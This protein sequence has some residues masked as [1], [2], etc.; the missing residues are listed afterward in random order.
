LK[1]RLLIPGPTEIDPEI[2]AAAARP[3]IGHRGPEMVELLQT[4]LPRVQRLLNTTNSVYP[5]ACSATG[6]MEATIRNAAP[7]RFLHL[8]CGAFGQRWSEIRA[9]CGQPGDDLAVEWGQASAPAALREQLQKDAYVAVT[10]V[11]NETSTGVLNPLA[12]LAQVVRSQSDA[13]LCVDT[14]SSMGA[15]EL[16][17]DRWGVDVC[18]AGTQKALALAPGLTLCAVSQR[19]LARSE[20]APSKG[21][22]FDFLTHERSLAKWQ[23]PATPAIAQ[24]FQL[25]LQMQRIEREGLAAR[26][27]RHAAM[28]D[29]TLAF[30]EAH[31]MVPF[32]AAGA[33]S[34]TVTTLRSG[35]RDLAALLSRAR[36]RGIILGSGYGKT[37]GDVFRVGH[38]GE[39]T[40]AELNEVLS[41]LDEELGR[42]AVG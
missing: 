34:V 22:Y 31:G 14:V 29:R 28:R 11:H 20:A 30:G 7:G 1:K 9:A 37:K 16:Q 26:Y 4:T 21:V 6:A 15:V 10:L 38:M 33:R 23:T 32:A 5:L 19:A 35:G 40:V 8:V 25:Q 13:L 41:M 27:A 12:E 18:L 36:E 39:W 2:A 24:L 42:M 17:L 3:M